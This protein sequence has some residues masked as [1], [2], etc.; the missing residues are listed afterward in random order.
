MLPSFRAVR[1]IPHG[2][3]ATPPALLAPAHSP[4]T[5]AVTAAPPHPAWPPL[6]HL[7]AQLSP[8]A[9]WLQPPRARSWPSVMQPIPLRLTGGLGKKGSDQR[10]GQGTGGTTRIS[11][12]PVQSRVW[13]RA[14][15]PKRPNHAFPA[16]ALPSFP[17]QQ[18][19][20]SPGPGSGGTLMPADPEVCL[21][22]PAFLSGSSSGHAHY[23]RPVS[24]FFHDTKIRP[25]GATG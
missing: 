17:S 22:S 20:P 15:F 19:P 7:Q 1:G 16:A 14:H 8:L 13:V 2:H 21:P 9:G 6:G 23:M 18:L 5:R 24:I 3:V 10:G 12:L 4:H 25:S 11:Q